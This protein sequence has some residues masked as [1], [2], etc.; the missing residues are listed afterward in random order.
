MASGIQWGMRMSTLVENNMTSV[1]RILEYGNLDQDIILQSTDKAASNG[2]LDRKGE[3][4]FK[5]VWLKCAA[6]HPYV[7]KGLNFSIA[8]GEK[9]SNICILYL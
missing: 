4:I 3:I 9:V 2:D 1:E 7:L 5:N 6:D 8:A